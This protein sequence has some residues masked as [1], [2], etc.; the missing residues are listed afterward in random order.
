MHQRIVGGKDWDVPK[1]PK[2]TDAVGACAWQCSDG[3]WKPLVLEIKPPWAPLC[4]PHADHGPWQQRD[5]QR[6]PRVQWE[7]HLC[8]PHGRDLQ[9]LLQQQDVHHDPQDCD[10]HHRHRGG[11]QG[12]GHGDRRWGGV[13]E[14]DQL[15]LRS[16][17]PA[18]MTWELE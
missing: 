8:C 10:V 15:Q 1:Q 7:I 16:F 17:F 12:A 13:L 6:R 9:V 18:C 4:F 14:G 11:S 3:S 5:L 2:I